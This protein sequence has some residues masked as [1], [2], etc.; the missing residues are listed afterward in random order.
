MDI[1]QLYGMAKE[2]SKKGSDK[3]ETSLNI[4]YNPLKKEDKEK[5]LSKSELQRVSK[6]ISVDEIENGWLVTILCHYV[7]KPTNGNRGGEMI[8]G[9]YIT[10]KKQ[11]YYSQRPTEIDLSYND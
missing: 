10:E 1:T 8:S 11:I 4:T 6:S 2:G 5:D 9:D 7:T 3:V